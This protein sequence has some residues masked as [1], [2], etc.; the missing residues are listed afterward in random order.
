VLRTTKLLNPLLSIIVSAYRK[1][2]PE[3]STR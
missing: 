3:S 1:P 2:T